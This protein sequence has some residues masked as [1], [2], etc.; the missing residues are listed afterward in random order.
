MFN[1]FKIAYHFT[2]KKMPFLVFISWPNKRYL[3][4]FLHLRFLRLVRL[5]STSRNLAGHNLLR[6]RWAKQQKQE[7]GDVQE[8]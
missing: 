1:F 6:Y 3:L 8:D 2:I 4:S 5:W 7:A